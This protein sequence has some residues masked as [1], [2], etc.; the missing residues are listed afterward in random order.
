MNSPIVRRTFLA[1]SA[2]AMASSPSSG[3]AANA[4]SDRLAKRGGGTLYA[5]TM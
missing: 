4:N 1:I 2:I 3:L 5:R